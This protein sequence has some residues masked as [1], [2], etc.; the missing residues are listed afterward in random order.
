[1]YRN[2]K[3]LLIIVLSLISA[4]ALATAFNIK[5][6]LPHTNEYCKY[7]GNTVTLF[8]SNNR[9]E[10]SPGGNLVIDGDFSKPFGLGIQVNNWYWVASRTPVQKGPP[11]NPDNS[12]AQF[13]INSNCEITSTTKP[14]YGAGIETY[15]IVDVTSMKGHNGECV[16]SINENAYTNAVTPTCCAPPNIGSNTCSSNQWGMTANGKKWPPK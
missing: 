2:F 16:V 5:N 14:V 13:M 15:L 10:I 12:G 8:Y 4:S 6:N 1:M 11:Q 7:S 3:C 9:P